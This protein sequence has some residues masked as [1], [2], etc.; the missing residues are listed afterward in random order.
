MGADSE[1]ALEYKVKAG[2][3][4]N[5]AR[6]VEWPKSAL[7]SAESPIVIGVLDTGEA[8]PWIQ[9]VLEGKTL[10]GR[11]VHVR[12][13]NIEGL[14]R[15]LHMIFVARAAGISPETVRSAL[16]R[17]PTLLVGETDSFAERGGM[18]GFFRENG[19]I[20]FKLNLERAA[21]ANLKIS[22]KLSSVAKPV[23]SNSTQ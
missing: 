2:Y 7:P 3:L 19:S 18:I 16:G 8:L 17:A 6:F 15:D 23:K 4:F 21:Q 14:S 11:R 12:A 9:A 10:D 13:V 20:R 22:A 1:L 5:F